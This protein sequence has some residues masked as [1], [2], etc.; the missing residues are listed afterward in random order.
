MLR[1]QIHYPQYRGD[2]LSRPLE[3]TLKEIKH[4]A[5]SICALAQNNVS[6]LLTTM[7]KKCKANGADMMYKEVIY[8][9]G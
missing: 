2:I 3:C 5:D 8:F 1:Q 9:E 6:Y 4:R 7:S